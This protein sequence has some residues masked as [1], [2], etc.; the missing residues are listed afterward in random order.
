MSSVFVIIP[1]YGKPN[2]TVK[3]QILAHNLAR[4]RETYQWSRIL[5]RICV[6]D[7]TE[8][9][10]YIAS[11]S[12]IEIVREPGLP[13]DFLKRYATPEDVEDFDYVLILFD[14]ILLQPSVDF[15][16]MIE[17]KKYFNLDIVSPTLSLDSEYQFEYMRTVPREQNSCFLKITT[18]CELFCFLM[19]NRM[20]ASYY[21]HIDPEINPWLWGLDMLLHY[22]FRYRVGMMN[23]MTMKHFYRQTCYHK[24]LHRDPF[25]GYNATIKKYGIDDDSVLTTQPSTLY[26]IMEPSRT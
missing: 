20:Y 3:H 9:P 25:V 4:I 13:G 10:D 11:Y 21:E 6:Y 23:F 5:V 12:F 16:K 19:D 15:E 17:V 2:E 26:W 7:D 24:H 8:I 14:D 1:G 22:K 18:C